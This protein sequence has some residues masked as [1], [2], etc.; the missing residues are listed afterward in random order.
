MP[1]DP[2][3]NSYFKEAQVATYPPPP[4]QLKVLYE[5]LLSRS[6]YALLLSSETT[7]ERGST[8]PVLIANCYDI[9][10]A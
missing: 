6:L 8:A 2:S 4:P 7:R 1:Q 9:A 3:S 5:T 10:T